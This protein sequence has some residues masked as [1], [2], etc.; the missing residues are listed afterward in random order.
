[1]DSWDLQRHLR[2]ST[3]IEELKEEVKIKEI[4]W[5]GLPLVRRYP[6]KTLIIKQLEEALSMVSLNSNSRQLQLDERHFILATI[7]R[8][9]NRESGIR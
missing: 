9:S 8:P 2:D 5:Q 4:S 1:M 3:Q 7:K 6:F